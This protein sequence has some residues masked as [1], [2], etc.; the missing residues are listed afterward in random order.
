M[1]AMS[2]VPVATGAARRWW[3]AA[4]AVTGVRLL[5][6]P[7]CAHAILGSHHGVAAL[8]FGLAVATDFAD[9][10]LARRRGEVSPLGGLLD[11]ATDALFVTLGLAAL[12]VGATMPIAL[13]ILV[14]A[15]FTQ[16]ALDSKAV[17]GRPL[18]TSR[19][20]RWNGIAYYV[21]LGVPVVRDG[22]GLGWPADPWVLAFGWALVIS[23]IA[24]MTDR[25]LALRRPPTP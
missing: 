24:S 11:H 16:Y 8:L 21:A 9:G 18:R 10:P 19:L 7:A 12:A 1:S 25:L 20:G 23:T 4:N 2:D 22:L 5:A 17:S 3:T 14:A 6:A 13:P 15:A